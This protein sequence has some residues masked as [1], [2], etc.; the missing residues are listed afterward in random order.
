MKHRIIIEID[1]NDYRDTIDFFTDERTLRLN[2]DYLWS[3]EEIEEPIDF[4]GGD[5]VRFNMTGSVFARMEYT[6]QWHGTKGINWD[7]ETMRK[8]IRDGDAEFVYRPEDHS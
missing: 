4:E 1:V 8:A 3:V 5:V 6:D 7:D 2:G